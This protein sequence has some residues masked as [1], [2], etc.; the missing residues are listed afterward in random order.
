MAPTSWLKQLFFQ[1][2][3]FIKY[4]INI[5]ILFWS[6]KQIEL[7]ITEVLKC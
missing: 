3:V 6:F 1:S 2:N 7:N 5:Y 4:K